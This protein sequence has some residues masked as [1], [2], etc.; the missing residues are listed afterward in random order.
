MVYVNQNRD[1]DC[2]DNDGKNQ[3]TQRPS[4]RKSLIGARSQ[5]IVI[6]MKS[7]DERKSF[8]FITNF[9]FA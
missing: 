7:V 2:D 8:D 5:R 6:D 4:L 3:I 1:D 9:L